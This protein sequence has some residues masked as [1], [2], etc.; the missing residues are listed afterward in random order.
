MKRLLLLTTVIAMVFVAD[1]IYA[2]AS[3]TVY[4]DLPTLKIEKKTVQCTYEGSDVTG[5]YIFLK[6]TNKTSNS[7]NVS[8]HLNATYDG[9]CKTCG[10]AEY[11]FSFTVPANSSVEPVCQFGNAYDKLAVFV[12][13]LNRPNYAVFDSFDLANLIVQ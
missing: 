5:E 4:Q 11:D 8:Y 10:N 3:W 6:L 1:N 12:K 7:I 13:H 9:V 2:Q